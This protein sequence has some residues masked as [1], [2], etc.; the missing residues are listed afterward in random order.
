[1]IVALY[2][3]RGTQVAMTCGPTG[4]DPVV[5]HGLDPQVVERVCAGALRCADRL[6]ALRFLATN[7]VEEQSEMP[8]VRN[9]GLF[10]T[11]ELLHGLPQRPDWLSS[12]DAG[13]NL[14]HEN[15]H[16]L[17]LA[18][19]YE[20][21]SE[22]ASTN[23]IA[24]SGEQRAVAVILDDSDEFETPAPKFESVSAVSH[25]LAVTQID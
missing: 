15:G 18:L 16:S 3:E 8:G 14:M 1:M 17:L 24:E 4:P 10:A 6:A 20:V 23:V 11:N 13:S 12:V 2:G 25:G 19:G 21:R 5:H 7:E 22:N 9:V